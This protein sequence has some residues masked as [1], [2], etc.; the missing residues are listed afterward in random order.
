M[1]FRSRLLTLVAITKRLDVKLLV[2]TVETKRFG[3]SGRGAGLHFMSS[4]VSLS[5]ADPSYGKKENIER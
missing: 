1:K 3:A 2:L 5:V 4:R